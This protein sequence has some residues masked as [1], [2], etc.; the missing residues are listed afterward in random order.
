VDIQPLRPQDRFELRRESLIA[1]DAL[2][3]GVAGAERDDG[4]SMGRGS[5][6]YR[7]PRKDRNA[8]RHL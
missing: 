2:A 6:D 8:S 4:R 3:I 7:Y 5:R 1:R